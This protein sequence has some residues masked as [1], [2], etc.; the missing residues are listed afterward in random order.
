M[1]AIDFLG[2]GAET[3]RKRRRENIQTQENEEEGR[4]AWHRNVIRKLEDEKKKI[5]LEQDLHN[6]TNRELYSLFNDLQG[7]S[8]EYVNQRL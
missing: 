7:I 6:K 1:L 8:T 2:E 4:E 5:S 3:S